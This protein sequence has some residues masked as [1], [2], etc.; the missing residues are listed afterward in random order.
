MKYVKKNKKWLIGVGLFLFGLVIFLVV[1]GKGTTEEYSTFIVK[2]TPLVQ[3][4]SEVGIVKPV[5]EVSLNFLSSGRVSEILVK[6]GDQVLVDTP[7]MKLDSESLELKK[8]ETEAGLKIAQANLSK[9]LA[10]A[11]SQSVNVSLKEIEQASSNEASARVDLN[12][13]KKTVSENIKQAQ[14][15]LDNLE[16]SGPGTNTPQEQAVAS[17]Q[18]ALDNT[19]RSSENAIENARDSALLVLSDKVLVGEVALDN[20]KTILED[21]DGDSVLGVEDDST[22]SSTKSSRLDALDLLP[23]VKDAIKVAKNSGESYDI[24]LA[25]RLSKDYL[26][27]VA[28]AL[29]NAFSMLEATITSANYPQSKLDANKSLV[30]SQSSQV[31]VAANTV[32]SSIQ[33]YN[34]AN[35]SYA[36]SLASA[37][38]NLS[39]AQVA[40]SNAIL[41]ARNALSNATLS[42]NQQIIN[43]E[44]RLDNAINS[45]ALAQAR[46]N[47][48]SAPARPQDIALAKAQVS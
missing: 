46:L 22:V 7:L 44:A 37:E 34:N 11:S 16:S 8:I 26:V 27:K 9:I 45:V 41:N 18:V 14:A 40:L 23:S 35:V 43:A 48:V 25:G 47:S 10:G 32:E 1:R 15:N 21:D 24:S 29:S 17:A 36:S 28:L 42:G 5:Q 38:Q 19:K 33:A 30:I 20:L 39:Q 31:N 4:V 6:V 3:T 2:A 13:I 12:Q